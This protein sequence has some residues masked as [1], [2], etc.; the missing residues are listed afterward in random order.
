MTTTDQLFDADSAHR[1]FGIEFN[2]G[3]FSFLDKADRTEEETE[4]MIAMAFASYLHWISYSGHDSANIARGLYMISTAL[5]YA[6]RREGAL[7][8][9]MLTHNAT[10]KHPEAM[11]DFDFC[12]AAMALAR[13]HALCG[14]PDKAKTF[15]DECKS[16][17][18]KVAD[19]EDKKIVMA[20]LEAGPWY[21]LR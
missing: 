6:G 21:G 12:Y 5:A 19:P 8:Y 10:H 2:N 11:A 20:D 3:V 15:L 4:K 18:E 17:A 14:H 16:L 7:H 9:A 13:A 1:R